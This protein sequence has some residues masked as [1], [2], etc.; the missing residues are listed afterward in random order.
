MTVFGNGETITITRLGAVTSGYDDAGDP[1]RAAPSTFDVTDV[2]VAP[3]TSDESAELFGDV[4]E[5]GYTLYLPYGTELLA[6]DRV[7]VR[8]VAGWQVVGD[9]RT[10]DWRS[11]FSGWT[12]GTVAIVRRAS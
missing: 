7:T 4:A 10:V 9:A 12:P 6:T 8:G 3:I 5:N 11:P 2:G 1:N